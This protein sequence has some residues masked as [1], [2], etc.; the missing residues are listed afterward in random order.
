MNGTEVYKFAV[1]EVPRVVG[2]CLY[3]CGLEASDVN[4]L[5]LHQANFKIMELATQV[6]GIPIEKVLI[7]L[8]QYGNTSTGSIPLALVEAV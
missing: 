8:D 2:K 1:S 7:N 3:N 6:L 5:S 4:R